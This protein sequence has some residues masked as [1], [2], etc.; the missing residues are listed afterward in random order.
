M[1]KYLLLCLFIVF[2]G[3][4]VKAESNAADKIA[5]ESLPELVS[6]V[7][8][9]GPLYFCGEPV[10]LEN[11]EV[12]ERLEKELLLILWNR[13]QVILWLKRSSRYFPYIER[14]LAQHNMPEDLKYIAVVESALLPHAGS[15]KGAVGY[16][17]FIKQTGR[18]Y[19][20]TINRDIDER[21]NFFASTK[22]ALAYLQDLHDLFGS[23]TLA[24]A[25]YNIGEDRIQDEKTSQQVDSYYEFYLPL[26]TQRYIFKIIA[27]KLI[28]THS[29]R[30]G[31]HLQEEDYYPPV[32]FDRVKISLPGRTPLFLVAQASGT[33]F[34]KIKDLNPQVRGHELLKGTHIIA[35]PEGTGEKFHSRFAGLAEKWRQEH[36]MHIYIVQKGDSLSTIAERFDVTL[37]ALMAWND[38]SPSNFIH[39][40][41]RLVIYQ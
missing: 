20:L 17:Q 15:S 8:V 41:E 9:E 10:P 14:M 4:T 2:A 29:S 7:R 24:A 32:T 40:G 28:F 39:P 19:G 3:T 35:V 5:P 11:H 33:N 36:K 16:W 23:W 26:E 25:A 34:K 12:R 1:R 30:Y 38:L 37:P 27:A 6:A 21:R 18:T 31:F 13:P 22:A